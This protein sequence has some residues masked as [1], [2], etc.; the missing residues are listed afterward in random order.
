[1]CVKVRSS[2]NIMLRRTFEDHQSKGHRLWTAVSLNH[3]FVLCGKKIKK[4]LF[5]VLIRTQSLITRLMEVELGGFFVRCNGE[6]AQHQDK[7]RVRQS[8][9]SSLVLAQL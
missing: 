5:N 2:G 8:T 6:T 3:S 7:G 1:M 4:A 9:A